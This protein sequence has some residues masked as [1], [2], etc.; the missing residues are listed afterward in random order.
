MT[1]S[2]PT[3]K[4]AKTHPSEHDLEQAEAVQTFGQ[5][6][7]NDDFAGAAEC[8]LE[9]AGKSAI[10]ARLAA[11]LVIE[12]ETRLENAD[13]SKAKKCLGLLLKCAPE[14][15][16]EA[17][18]WFADYHMGELQ[19]RLSTGRLASYGHDLESILEYAPQ[20]KAEAYRL[21]AQYYMGKLRKI[22]SEGR[23]EAQEKNVLRELLRYGPERRDEA[24]HLFA[25]R[26]M[27]EMR[28]AL[29]DYDKEYAKMA[30]DDFLKYAPHRKNEA[31]EVWE[32][33]MEAS[34]QRKL[35]DLLGVERTASADEVRSAYRA[36][37]KRLH[38]DVNLD[39][40]A[41][42][43]QMKHVNAAYAILGDPELRVRYDQRGDRK[44]QN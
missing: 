29:S 11:I 37:A 22:L 12:I 39:N 28:Q 7:A 17:C 18:M 15:K 30:L 32:Q 31:M 38:P 16:E 21:V 40:P 35:Y 2:K 33:H 43:D 34:R 23:G 26:A 20:R 42:A 36:L 4:P 24:Y 3:D 13:S 10:H 41:A 25:S 1:N 27:D 44:E 9:H 14:R 8:I 19:K 5:L 6:L